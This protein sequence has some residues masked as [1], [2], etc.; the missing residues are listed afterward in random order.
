MSQRTIFRMNFTLNHCPNN[1]DPEL[2]A[3]ER[4]FYTWNSGYSAQNYMFAEHKLLKDRTY[5]DYMSKSTGVFD[6][7]HQLSKDEI[8]VLKKSIQN[9]NSHIWHPIISLNDEMSAFM[10]DPNDAAHFLNY[11]LSPLW[12]HSQLKKDKVH[13]VA[14][15][16]KDTDNRHMHISIWEKD[17]VKENT[18]WGNIPQRAMDEVVVK[19]SFYFFEKKYQLHKARDRAID[20]LKE[21]CPSARSWENQRYADSVRH[22][23][24]AL[25]TKLPQTG[26]TQ[27]NSSSMAPLRDDVDKLVHYM[28]SSDHTLRSAYDE[29]LSAISGVAKEMSGIMKESK[30]QSFKSADE[31]GML[32]KIKEDIKARMGNYVISIAKELQNEPRFNYS[33]N[34]QRDTEK[35][36]DIARKQMS[37]DET[38]STTAP[39]KSKRTSAREN[40]STTRQKAKI[41][42]LPPKAIAYK[43][44]AQRTRALADEM[45]NKCRA[46]A[47]NDY[48]SIKSNWIYD[49]LKIHSQKE[50]EQ[51]LIEKGLLDD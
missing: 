50:Y 9:T 13:V 23:L 45:A 38:Y 8:D 51:Q 25:A 18:F 6:L 43:I 7:T 49:Y 2:W 19:S 24:Y 35:I 4:A 10:N 48:C 14:G 29:Y 16:H 20:A 40:D 5:N 17:D 31:T 36:V 39:N 42:H 15:L 30:V 34:Q 46:M 11:A 32:R 27:Y 33:K 47:A 44:A 21:F 3:K 41:H 28:I 37:D 12:E 1:M 22:K 26:R